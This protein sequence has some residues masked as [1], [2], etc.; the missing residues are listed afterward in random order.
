MGNGPTGP[1][2]STGPT[3]TNNTAT[4]AFA[5]NLT[6]ASITVTN[7]GVP[8]ALPDAQVLPA[9]ITVNPGNNTFTV[10]VTGRYRISYHVNTTVA[11][12]MGTRITINGAPITQSTVLPLIS[13]S[14]F[15]NEILIDLTAGDAITLQL[16]G[17]A[18]LAILLDASAGASLMI[19]RLS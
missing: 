1:T 15:S 17:L 12:I 8:V 19:M 9:G 5:A 16:F 18:G 10:N 14:T 11:L 13:L 6:G 2:G 4:T 3:G 7:P